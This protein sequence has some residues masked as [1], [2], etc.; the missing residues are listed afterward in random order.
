[1]SIRVLPGW[2]YTVTIQAVPFMTPWPLQQSQE[3]VCRAI[4]AMED[5]CPERKDEWITGYQQGQPLKT[6]AYRITGKRTTTVTRTEPAR[7]WRSLLGM[8]WHTRKIT[9]EVM[10]RDLGLT[11]YL[12]VCSDGT[13]DAAC[14]WDWG[15]DS[16]AFSV[17]FK[18]DPSRMAP[19]LKE[20]YDRM[21]A[22]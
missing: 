20:I 16:M 3:R 13:I 18:S 6:V 22:A 15:T 19:L 5:L 21:A 8:T 11:L 7:G 10:S 12:W 14:A 4:E 9:T 1:M 17:Y 2:P